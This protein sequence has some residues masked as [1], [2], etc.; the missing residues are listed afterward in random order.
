M[1]QETTLDQLELGADFILPEMLN[2][3]PE[4][5]RCLK[6][7]NDGHVYIPNPQHSAMHAYVSQRIDRCAKVLVQI[8]EAAD[9]LTEGVKAVGTAIEKILDSVRE[10][11]PDCKGTGQYHGL[12]TVEICSSCKGTGDV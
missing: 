4:N 5:K 1:W 2:N 12:F 8:T 7:D 3:N 11:C 10:D 6:L 9:A